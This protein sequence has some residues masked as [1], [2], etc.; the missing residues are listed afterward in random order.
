MNTATHP[1]ADRVILV[2]GMP[3]QVRGWRHEL[4][5]AMGVQTLGFEDS[6]EA[7]EQFRASPCI[8]GVVQNYV[9]SDMNGMQFAWAL[10]RH[11]G[12]RGPIVCLTDCDFDAGTRSFFSE[13][14]GMTVYGGLEIKKG[15][16][17]L[18]WAFSTAYEFTRPPRRSP[19]ASVDE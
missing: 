1:H 7:L 3:T 13:I 9:R 6:E 12:F 2:V 11:H 18:D 5:S 17:R 19:D 15:I 10:R 8:D 14:Y 4:E 16:A